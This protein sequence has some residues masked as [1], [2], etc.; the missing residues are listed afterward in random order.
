MGDFTDEEGRC[1]P[2]PITHIENYIKRF[3][4]IHIA[5]LTF[6]R[7]YFSDLRVLGLKKASKFDTQHSICEK[8]TSYC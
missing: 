6:F 2:P 7:F 4:Y 3:R 8:I 1:T 5:Y